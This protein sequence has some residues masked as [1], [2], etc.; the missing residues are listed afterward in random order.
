M[1]GSPLNNPTPAPPPNRGQPLPRRISYWFAEWVRTL[2][3]LI[4]CAIALAV[5]LAVAYMA[6]VAL[7]R[8]I[9]WGT[10]ALGLGA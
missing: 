8:F 4:A 1:A 3:A 5:A 6:V 7:L 10:S 9:E 2:I